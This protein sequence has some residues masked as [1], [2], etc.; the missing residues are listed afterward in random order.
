MAIFT[1]EELAD[2][3]K[4]FPELIMDALDRGDIEG[5]RKWCRRHAD[6]KNMI[7]DVYVHWIT[8]LMSII[9]R[10]CGEPAAVEA[11]RSLVDFVGEQTIETKD[12]I[13]RESGLKAWIEASMD[14][15]RQHGSYPGVE[16]EEDEEKV[17]VRLHSC[18]S[19]GKMINAGCFDGPDAYARIREPGPHTWGEADVPIYCSHCA[20]AHELMPLEALGL[21]GQLWVHEKPFPRRAGDPC[22]HHFYKDAAAIP[23]RYVRRFET[24]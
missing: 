13:M 9:H 14:I 22:V 16:V 7:H 12:R 21:G 10:D 19:G 23:A 1:Q 8:Q 11:I 5:A 15:W 4:D 2:L 17:T 18:G 24:E 6:S 20:L 3:G